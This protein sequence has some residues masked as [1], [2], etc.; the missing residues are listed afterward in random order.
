MHKYLN[1]PTDVPF[2][3]VHLDPNNP[4][5]APEDRPGYEDSELLFLASVQEPLLAKL[6]KFHE[7]DSLEPTITSQGWLPV[8][9]MLVWEHPKRPGQ[10]VVIEGNTRTVVL[11]RIRRKLAHERGH[12]KKME[13]NKGK[14]DKQDLEDQRKL[15][16]QLQQIVN[17][18]ESLNVYS[19]RATSAKELK[20]LC[21]VCTVC[22]T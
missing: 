18:T 17:D 9:P 2:G 16:A 8:D 13:K 10:Y 20:E 3:N 12:L 19:I 11:R 4:R 21:P 6:E 7:V 15:V 14:Y 1:Q 5:T 22:A